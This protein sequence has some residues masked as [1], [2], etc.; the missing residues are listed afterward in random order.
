M[1]RRFIWRA[2]ARLATDPKVRAKAGELFERE[3]KPR[4][5]ALS[6]RME[7]ALRA[8]RDDVG[9]AARKADPLKNPKEFAAQLKDRL[10]NRRRR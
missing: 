6:R 8:V 1:M 5:K 2:A 4:A 3:L 9:E 10:N 7:P